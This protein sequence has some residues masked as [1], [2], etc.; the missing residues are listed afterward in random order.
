MSQRQ[1]ILVPI[2]AVALLTAFF[3]GTAG[4]IAGVAYEAQTSEQAISALEQCVEAGEAALTDLAAAL[5]AME[6]LTLPPTSVER[7]RALEAIVE[8]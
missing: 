6:T 5:A 1:S 2:L 8:P 4:F 3:W 7:T